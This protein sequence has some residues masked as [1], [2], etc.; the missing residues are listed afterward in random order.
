M[1]ARKA[2][3]LAYGAKNKIGTLLGYK[4]VFG[5]GAMQIALTP[6][7]ARAYGYF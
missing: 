7:F 1:R 2:P 3:F 5:L 4:R 6:H